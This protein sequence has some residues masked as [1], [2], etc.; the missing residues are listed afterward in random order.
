MLGLYATK[1]ALPED[2]ADRLRKQNIFVS[3][4][5]NAIRV[6]PHLYN[7]LNDIET[8]FRAIYL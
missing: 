2:L 6:A 5:G 1:T 7:D 3:V 8:L 4:R